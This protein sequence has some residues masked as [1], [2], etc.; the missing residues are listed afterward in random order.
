MLCDPSTVFVDDHGAKGDGVT[1]DHVALENAAASATGLVVLTDSKV[2]VV[3]NVV[4]GVGGP[5]W[6]GPGATLK[7]CDSLS[8]VLTAPAPIGATSVEVAD[9]TDFELG[10]RITPA[11]G[12]TSL[13]GEILFGPKHSILSVVE[14]TIYFTDGLVKSYGVGDPV[15]VVFDT[16]RGWEVDD[17]SVQDL[18]FDGNARG[19]TLYYSWGAGA[20]LLLRGSNLEI[21]GNTFTDIWTIGLNLSNVSNVVVEDNQFLGGSGVGTHLSSV[22]SARFAGND[23]VDLGHEAEKLHHSEAAMTW[24]LNNEDV[25]VVRSCFADNVI[26]GMWAD[27]VRNRGIV[28]RGNLSNGTLLELSLTGFPQG[29]WIPTGSVLMEDNVVVDGEGVVLS[30]GGVIPLVEDIEIRDNT[31]QNGGVTLYQSVSPVIVDNVFLGAG[32]PDIDVGNSTSPV[33]A[34]NSTGASVSWSIPCGLSSP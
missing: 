25:T 17:F 26:P 31:I 11:S 10:M 34:G 8:S 14:N 12:E 5:T 2:Y 22:T 1:Y 23:F 30:V 32:E 33:I 27:L 4:R 24:S 9:A 15:L 29:Y 19:N 28:A 13:D 3:C 16:L 21:R 6:W 7:R 18:A 20:D